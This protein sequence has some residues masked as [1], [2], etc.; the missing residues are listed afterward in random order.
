MDNCL[1]YLKEYECG[2]RMDELSIKCLLYANDQV[3]LVPSACI[4]QEMREAFTVN[5]QTVALSRKQSTRS[6]AARMARHRNVP[7]RTFLFTSKRVTSKSE[8]FQTFFKMFHCIFSSRNPDLEMNEE[9]HNR[10]LLL[11]QDMC[12]NL[13]C[14]NLLVKLGM[15]ALNREMKDPFSRELEREREYGHQKLDLVVQ[16]NVPLLNP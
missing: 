9:I 12:Y 14:G 15:P 16:M 4:L 11:I 3:I 8:N 1:Y 2:L 6:E 13:M 10:A 5:A 7:L